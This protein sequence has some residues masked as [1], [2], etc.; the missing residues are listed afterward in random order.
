MTIETVRHKISCAEDELRK[1]K[2]EL[3]RL[4]ANKDNAAV[5]R[6]RAYLDKIACKYIQSES[7]GEPTI[8]IQDGYGFSLKDLYDAAYGT[9]IEFRM[10][11]NQLR[12]MAY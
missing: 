4:E 12:F 1:A 5:K 11:R 7:C 3:A 6:V 8:I 2:N 10:D 9:N